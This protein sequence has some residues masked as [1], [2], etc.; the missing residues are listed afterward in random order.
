LDT[1]LV[2]LVGRG[3]RFKELTK[4]C[5]RFKINCINRFVATTDDRGI[6]NTLTFIAERHR[7]N[8]LFLEKSDDGGIG[9][10]AMESRDLGKVFGDLLNRVLKYYS[11]FIP[12]PT[13]TGYP[14]AL[15]PS[16]KHLNRFMEI[17]L[18]AIRSY[19]SISISGV[20]RPARIRDAKTVESII[21]MFTRNKHIY[22]S[23]RR[24]RIE[25]SDIHTAFS[26]ILQSYGGT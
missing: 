14:I 3:Q 17:E 9:L 2:I 8:V 10:V 4:W 23:M 13:F 12:L 24:M 1:Y 18:P 15:F 19:V 20:Y 7:A 11:I 22:A 25:E 5:S 6:A 16:D 21:H 26:N